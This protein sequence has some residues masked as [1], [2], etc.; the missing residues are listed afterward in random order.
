MDFSLTFEELCAVLDQP[1]C[2]GEVPEQVRGVAS[3]EGAEPSDLS[4]LGN[5][6]YRKL[7]ATSKAGVILL[8]ADYEGEP[9]PGQAFLRV[10]DPSLALAKVSALIEARL[11]PRPEPGIH[12]SAVVE[13]GAEVDPGATVG[14]LALIMAGARVESG[15]VIHGSAVVGRGA[16]IGADSQIFP[17]AVIADYCEV[18][19]RCRVLHGAVIG[20]DGYGYHSSA[21]GHARIPQVG[22]VVLE[23]DVDVGA[24][25]T[26][27]RARFAQTRIGSGTRI[28]NLVM[29]G[30]NVRVG[31]HCL[32][33]AQAGISGSC[34]LGDFVVIGGQ[35]GFAGHIHIGDGAMV[36]AQAGISKDIPPG[37]KLRGSPALPIPLYQRLFIL[38]KRLPE[39]FDRLKNLESQ[40]AEIP[41]LRREKGEV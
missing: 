34:T 22:N 33:V 1:P 10:D 16:R 3:L 11:W 6:K 40:L 17:R 8:P 14:A 36:G 21:A 2:V 4:F 7:V 15:A 19:A 26:L 5:R 13:P 39:V 9:Q 18:G 35:A 29:I 24:N 23:D 31:R 30:H 32:I 12:P 20:S 25:S 37:D 28:D 38:Q 27:D 41:S